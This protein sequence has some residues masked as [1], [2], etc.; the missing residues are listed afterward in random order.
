MKFKKIISTVIL[1][2]FLWPRVCYAQDKSPSPDP[3]ISNIIPAVKLA[4]GEKDP[5]KAISPMRKDQKAPFTGVLLSPAAVADIIVEIQ[6]MEENIHIEVS[7][8][9][10]KQL[11]ECDKKVSDVKTQ[12]GADKKILQ[13]E[14]EEKN[15]SIFILND[16]LKKEKDAQ[17]SPVIWAGIGTLGGIVVT[18]LTVFAVS[19][20]T[21]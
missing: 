4:P 13:A 12:L 20:A 16:Q 1:T 21:K 17:T 11:A 6:S 18:L 10:Q 8:A 9:V 7:N 15:K 3:D 5:G 2:S 19:K 14:I